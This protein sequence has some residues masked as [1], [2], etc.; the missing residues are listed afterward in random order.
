VNRT[1]IHCHDEILEQRQRLGD[2]EG[3]TVIDKN[4]QD[5]LLTLVERKRHGAHIPPCYAT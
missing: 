4:H 3:D 2:F 5:M 1:S